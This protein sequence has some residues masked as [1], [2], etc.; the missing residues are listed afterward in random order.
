[1]AHRP[2]SRGVL[3][4]SEGCNFRSA[5]GA[6]AQSVRLCRW[7]FHTDEMENDEPRPPRTADLVTTG[8]LLCL[9]AGIAAIVIVS[10]F[11]LVMTTDACAYQQC[12]DERWVTR[13]IYVALGGGVLTV[14]LDV[15]LAVVL[16]MKHRIAFYV[17]VI[18]CAVQIG[19]GLLV[20]HLA[21]LAGPIA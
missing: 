13:A 3:S 15:L 21:S 6:S 14:L 16:L 17:P 18:G 1:M 12:G 8:I 10:S 9:H 2:Q 7:L 19:I 20:L 5:A 4:N 11:F